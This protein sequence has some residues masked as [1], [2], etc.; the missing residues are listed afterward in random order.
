MYNRK[1]GS[2]AGMIDKSL[3]AGAVF[4]AHDDIKFARPL[5]IQ[6]AIPT[7]MCCST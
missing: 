4:L 7:V 5:P 1:T 3:L 2:L 6:F